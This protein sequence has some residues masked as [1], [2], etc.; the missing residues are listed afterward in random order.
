[1]V[2]RLHSLPVYQLSQL[3]KRGRRRLMDQ[4]AGRGRTLREMAVLAALTERGPSSQ[5]DLC[6][7][8]GQD[9]SDL[10]R[11]IDALEQAGL[12]RRERDPADRRR[13]LVTLTEGGVRE[14]EA[15][16][17]TAEAVTAEVLAPL[18]AEERATLTALLRR[19]L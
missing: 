10:V 5:R 2:D 11:T 9:P 14:L 16:E 7:L 19:C 17:Q 1:M 3:G 18:S 12:A 13:H 8:L 4:L 15:C 6:D